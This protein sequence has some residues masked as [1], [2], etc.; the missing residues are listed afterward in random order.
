VFAEGAVGSLHGA[1]AMPEGNRALL[2]II[3]TGSEGMVSA[4]FER[5]HCEIRRF[6]GTDRTL[7][8]EPGQWAVDGKRP[9]DTLVDLALGHG[10][11]RSP[12]EIG[13]ATVSLIEAMLRSAAKRAAVDVYTPK[14]R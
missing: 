12:G 11:N 9:T 8:I 13:A 5:D 10:D 4:E 3:V 1:A 14:E 2:H 6:D 7:P